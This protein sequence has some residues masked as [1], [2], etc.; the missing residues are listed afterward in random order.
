[1]KS[2]Y[3][4]MKTFLVLFITTAKPK[5]SNIG[6]VHQIGHQILEF[7]AEFGARTRSR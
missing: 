2:Q 3:L 7:G 1:M 5:E 6:A 4:F